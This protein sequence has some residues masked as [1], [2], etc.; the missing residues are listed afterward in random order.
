MAKKVIEEKLSVRKIE[1]MIRLE[2]LANYRKEK[3]NK[4]N[5]DHFKTIRIQIKDIEK[6]M[7]N[8]LN[9]ALKINMKNEKSGTIE[10]KYDTPEELDRIYLLINSINP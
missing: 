8:K 7:K 10:I 6:Q 3:D 2:K 9:A 4:L 1:D 5:N